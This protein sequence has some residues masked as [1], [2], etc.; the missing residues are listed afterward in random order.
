MI[1]NVT[2]YH[3]FCFQIFKMFSFSVNNAYNCSWHLLHG[4]C[5]IVILNSKTSSFSLQRNLS[6]LLL[7]DYFCCRPQNPIV[8]VESAD[9][10]KKE[11]TVKDTD[12]VHIETEGKKVVLL[13]RNSFQIM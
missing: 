12:D 2:S 13:H 11:T 10:E 1:L 6:A 4:L 3:L 9:V 8:I 5:I 7:N